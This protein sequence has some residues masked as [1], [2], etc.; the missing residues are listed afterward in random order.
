[1]RYDVVDTPQRHWLAVAGAPL[2]ELREA[3]PVDPL[4]RDE[5]LTPGR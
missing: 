1:M 4:A 3:R 2:D 5:V